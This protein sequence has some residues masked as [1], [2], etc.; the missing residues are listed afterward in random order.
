MPFKTGILSKC[1]YHPLLSFIKT[2]YL[3]LITVCDILY[4]LFLFCVFPISS[5]NSCGIHEEMNEEAEEIQIAHEAISLC[6]NF[7]LSDLPLCF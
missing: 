3:A 1:I 6:E 4:I 5:V 7:F 2:L